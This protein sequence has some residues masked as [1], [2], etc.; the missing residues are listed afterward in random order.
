MLADRLKYE[1]YSY[2]NW[3]MK[4]AA[5]IVFIG[6]D[7][8]SQANLAMGYPLMKYNREHNVHSIV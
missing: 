8:D 4:S 5:N 2:D 3:L 6:F 7:F 1:L